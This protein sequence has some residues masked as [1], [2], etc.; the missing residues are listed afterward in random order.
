MRAD[1][2]YAP[3]RRA[4]WPPTRWGMG[5]PQVVVI[6]GASAGVGRAAARAFA[7]RGCAVGLLARGHDGLDGAAK[8]V[9]A[10]AGKALRPNRGGRYPA[11][12][13]HSP[14]RAGRILRSRPCCPA[15]EEA[16]GCLPASGT[17]GP[18]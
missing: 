17:L 7:E 5:K 8:D 14:E 11:C 16:A 6:A 12:R 9:E 3:K 13:G 10:A 2:P 4:V 15:S 18:D 1:G